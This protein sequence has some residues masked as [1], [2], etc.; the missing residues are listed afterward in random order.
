MKITHGLMQGQVL[1]RRVNGL[2]GALI[3]GTCNASGAVELRVLKS[4]KVARGHDWQQV[5]SAD[6][7]T[8]NAMLAGLSTGG[9]YRVELRVKQGRKVAARAALDDVFVGDVWILAGQ[10]NMEGIGN[11]I[12]APKPHPQVRAFFMRDEW[13]M[14]E[15]KLHYLTEAVDV[16]HNSYGDE[17]GR[18]PKEVLEQGRTALVKGMSP[19]LV[20]GLEMYRR[21]RVPQGLI[22]CA[23]G[24]TSMA[25]WSPELRDQGGASLYGAMMRRY[26][27]LGQ[28]LAGVLWYQGE[29]DANAEAQR[30]YTKTMVELV[31]AVRRDMSLPKLPW[32]V[33]QLG[34]HAATE[35]DV[36][37][38]RIQEQQRL[39]PE[40]IRNLDVAP[41]IDLELDDG[42][43]IS[44][45]GQ[46]TLGRR[47]ARL[48]DRLVHKTPGVK[49]GIVLKQMAIVPTPN[50]NVGAPCSSVE[51]TY[52]NVVGRL[53]SEGRSTGFALLDDDG[54]DV[55]GIY[56]TT[57]EGRR[58]LLHTNMPEHMLD[59]LSVS[60]G[61]GRYPYC[62]I[63]DSDDMSIP[64]MQA[65]PI[66]PD[67][68]QY[69]DDWQTVRLPGV[70][71][72]AR[73]GFAKAKCAVGWRKAPP[74]GGFGV[75]PKLASSDKMGVYAMR[76]T[77]TASEA[78]DAQ[79]MFGA[80][81]AFKLWLNGKLLLTDP[82]CTMPVDPGQ[83]KVPLKLKCGP[84]ALVVAFAPEGP[85]AHFGICAR[86]GT[87]N[88]N[89]DPR[90]SS[91]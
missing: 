18:P 27:K 34:C 36:N 68:A 6:G 65:I 14:A 3:S 46:Q 79:L 31:A 23:H 15:E 81:G 72:I 12:H 24:G 78:L 89:G 33:V 30:V 9:P 76:T 91:A 37:W 56:K 43:H 13:A 22:P 26:V 70:S 40:A 20:F 84:N 75:L 29:S 4:R 80:N 7:K 67:H 52:G 82:A 61:H 17:P 60:Y 41:A 66:N 86:V 16:V 48:A 53:V 62:N 38:N 90:V 64:G 32:V 55:R 87:N 35:D 45:V 74:R 49:P 69:C 58:V 47:M 8:F 71:S 21:T 42:I 57:L 19:G 1:Q 10:S 50:C 77:L 54:R 25:Q 63:T 5:G 88:G 44:G 51:L 85:G 73:A 59:M 11:L 83:Y 2:G 39:L 28:P